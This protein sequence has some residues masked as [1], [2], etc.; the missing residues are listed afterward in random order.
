MPSYGAIYCSNTT[1]KTPGKVYFPFPNPKTESK[2]AEVRLK[3]STEYNI[4]TFKFLK[5]N[6]CTNNEVFH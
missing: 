1:E 6:H 4:N 3:N 2:R 5:D